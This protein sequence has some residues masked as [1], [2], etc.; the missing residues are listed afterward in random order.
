M[1][2][3][4]ANMCVTCVR[5]CCGDCFFFLC[6]TSLGLFVLY[7]FEGLMKHV[8]RWIESFCKR[9]YCDSC[10]Q[11]CT[12]KSQF[13]GTLPRYRLCYDEENVLIYVLMIFFMPF[14]THS[15]SVSK[16]RLACFAYG[17]ISIDRAIFGTLYLST[18]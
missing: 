6:Y 16:Y 15:N 7:T 18:L 8:Q 5:I 9:R 2:L 17:I 12:K 10:C 1:R 11:R 3:P 14:L 4:S 13:D